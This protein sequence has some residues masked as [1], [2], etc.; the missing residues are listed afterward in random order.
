MSQTKIK[1]PKGPAPPSPA[2]PGHIRR[3]LAWAAGTEAFQHR[4][5]L[6]HVTES[7]QQTFE[8]MGRRHAED[9][10]RAGGQVREEGEALPDGTD[11]RSFYE[12]QPGQDQ[13]LIRRFSQVAFQRGTLSGA[14]L[15]GT[16]QMMLFS[17]LKK[18]VGQSQPDKW[19]QRK[20]FEGAAARRSA[21]GH[22]PDRVIFNR[23]FAQ[24]AVALVVDALQDARQTVDSL[25]DLARGKGPMG[26]G[27]GADTLRAM[28]P[29]LDDRRERALLAEYGGQLSGLDEGD[30]ARPVL[31]NALARTHALIAKKEQMKQEFINKLRFLSDRASEALSVWEQPGYA[32]ALGRALEA[33]FAAVPPPDQGDG[34]AADGP[35]AEG[36][37]GHGTAGADRPAEAGG[38]PPGTGGGTP[39]APG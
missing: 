34:G 32:P 23:G 6:Y 1:R 8:A 39:A 18:T 35:P 4:D 19:Q 17:C 29:F 9:L 33:A 16:G 25:A 2:E 15:R 20:L 27:D 10:A 37:D 13:E 12:R 36:G 31:Q 24:S 14:I 26:P 5:P 11:A 38:A 22:S 28:Y 7:F 21:A 3:R 30:P